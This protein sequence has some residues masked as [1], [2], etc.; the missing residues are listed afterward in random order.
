MSHNRTIRTFLQSLGFVGLLGSSVTSFAQNR[1]PGEGEIQTGEIDIVRERKINLTTQNRNF[2][3][4]PASQS[5]RPDRQP[6]KYQFTDQKL[7]IA[8]P[9][10]NPAVTEMPK[11]Q[12][13][14]S[15][16]NSEVKAGAGNY[17]RFLLEANV[18]SRNDLPYG[19]SIKGLHNSTATGPVD[20]RNS[21]TSHQLIQVDGRYSGG[22]MKLTGS[23]GYD[24][25]QYYFYGYSRAIETPKREDI[26]QVL[27]NFN[28][29]IGIENT[30]KDAVI[31]YSIK[32]KLRSLST[33]TQANEYDWGT[34]LK[35]TFPITKN[36][37]AHLAGD[38][39]L[40]QRNDSLTN[41]RNLFRIKPTFQY[42]TDRFSVLAGINVVNETDNLNA[43]SKP[44]HAYPV[45]E[46]DLMP[47]ED[48][49]VFAGYQG[50]IHRNTLASL[51][52]ENPYLAPNV[53]LL[54]TEKVHDFYIG[55]KGLIQ[56]GFSYEAKVS[57][58]RYRNLYLF[59]NSGS[60]STRF[61]VLYDQPQDN[62]FS[63]VINVSG[64][65]NY[66]HED[67]WRSFL[68]FDVYGYDLKQI[69]FAYHR[70][71]FTATWSNTVTFSKK[72]I[73]GTDF[74]VITGLKGRNLN[75]GVVRTLAP[76]ID[77]NLRTTYLITDR[78]SAFVSVNNIVGK[79]FERFQYYKQQGVNFLAGVSY[80]F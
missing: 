58:G 24:R 52:D 11:S 21:G 42:R 69:D 38:A 35:A 17:G 8:P 44:T 12:N 60:D 34:N 32:T 19:L 56:G 39:Y 55:T 68:K 67:I 25:N 4:I 57:F 3:K 29:G 27:N 10:F 30:K 20:G 49:H 15:L 45:V 66:Q 26:K 76:I 6:L 79:N 75:S 9:Q 80:Q 51:T 70:P 41:S 47:V 14:G 48:I 2:E 22:S 7:L 61:S 23:L 18:N 59:N 36:F 72:L 53:R 13:D 1:N 16:F 64:Q 31:D 33:F 62:G 78:I 50:D 63:N 46:L 40:T 43:L 37:F 77:L 65:L 73:V 54:N 5:A 71:T 74:Y 28:V